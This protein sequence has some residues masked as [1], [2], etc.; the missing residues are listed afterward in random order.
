MDWSKK[1]V[2]VTGAGGFIGSHL[3]EELVRRGA[4]VKALVRYNSRGTYGWLDE[5]PSEIK[6]SIQFIQGDLRDYECIDKAV[7]GSDYVF[8]L[9][10]MIS[11]PYSYINPVEVIQVNLNGTQNVLNSC[12]RHNVVRMMNT[13]TSE[14]FGTALYVP[15]DEKHPYQGQSPYSASKIAA[16]KLVES[17]CRSFS[18]PAVTIRPF[19]TFGPRQSARA[20]IPTIISQL[21][22]GDQLK[23]GSLTPTRDFTFV[24]DTVEGMIA[25]MDADGVIGTEIN[26][27]TNSEISIGDLITLISKTMNIPIKINLDEKRIRPANSEVER[28]LSDNRKALS[29]MKWKPT[30]GLEEGINKTVKWMQENKNI[31]RRAAADYIV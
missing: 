12:L 3:T 30:I 11:I 4:T 25:S 2:L 6:K 1:V 27:G 15:I 17:Y 19:N 28:L 9:G 18:L 31:Y 14:V 21:L 22:V 16:D 20:V 8:H 13:S 23:L 29:T 10:A 5:A 7:K 24:T 26:L